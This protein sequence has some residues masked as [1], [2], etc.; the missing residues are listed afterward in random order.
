ML[1][2]S[3]SQILRI[4]PVLTA[5]CLFTFPAQAR[6]SG[7]SG[8]AQDPYQIATAADLI[9]LGETPA[10]YDKHFILTADIDLDP[11]LPGRKVFDKAVI[12][13]WRQTPFV[14]VFDGCGHV[15]AHLRIIGSQNLGLFGQLGHWTAPGAYVKNLGVVDVNVIDIGSTGRAGALAG[16]NCGTVI[17]CYT[18]GVVSGNWSVGGLVGDN[19]GPVTDCYSTAAVSGTGHDVGGLV[20]CNW[21][22]VTQCNSTGQVTGHGPVGGLVGANAGG[23]VIHCYSAGM[24]NG[25]TEV[26]GLVGDN[27]GYVGH[28]HSM[29]P[30]N[31]RLRVGGLVGSNS[32]V[33]PPPIYGYIT[34]CYSTGMVAGKSAV[35][36]LVGE[37]SEPITNCYSTGSVRGD[38]YVGGLVGHNLRGVTQCYSV[39]AVDGNDCVG[40]LVGLHGPGWSAE[41]ATACFWDIQTS[42]QTA[43]DGGDGKTTDQMQDMRTYLD[44]GWDFVDEHTNGTCEIW[45]TPGEDEYPVLAIPRQLQGDGTADDPYLISDALELG[46]IVHYSPH[47]HYRLVAS[48][49]LSGIRWNMPVIP[50]FRSTFDGAGHTVSNLTITGK[51][52][53]GLFGRLEGAAEVRNVG[54]VDVNI[55]GSGDYIGG[56]A[57]DNSWGTITKC[58]STGSVSGN[59]AVG[60]LVGKNGWYWPANIT[61]SY[62]TARV[63]GE[64]KIGGL[65]GWYTSKWQHGNV[66][67]CYSSGPVSGIGDVGGLL[68]YVLYGDV[69]ACFWD[70]QTSGQG[71]SA[72]G[73]GK[74]TA[75]MHMA[76]TFLE[77]GWDFVGETGNGTE[78]IWWIDEGKGYPRLWWELIPKN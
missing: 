36:G 2:A 27:F 8:T 41:R 14:G 58:Y 43:S 35:G 76:R 23:A 63:G 31:G 73:T 3:H 42:G 71:G 70:T 37:N 17:Q 47:A 68:G 10:D 69:T 77:A 5:T 33:E 49:D 24:V 75:Q 11:N 40:G 52:Y 28:C 16:D 55:T 78:D 67:Q 18:T 66:A 72:G 53:L 50:Y 34:L 57:G 13:D 29:G 12:A 30:V 25:D 54:V 15:I 21:G 7:G 51:S 56:L 48:I 46:A 62:S 26:G 61:N 65:V 9:A 74:T 59:L 60:G 38:E 20:G 22:S 6:Y 4:I 32:D 45:Q 19:S 1:G 64:S 39:G 44:A